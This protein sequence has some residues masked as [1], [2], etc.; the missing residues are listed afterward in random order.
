[1]LDNI[2]AYRR[3]D[4]GGGKAALRNKAACFAESIGFAMSNSLLKSL[5]AMLIIIVARG[6]RGKMAGIEF[7]GSRRRTAYSR[8]MHGF[9]RDGTFAGALKSFSLKAILKKRGEA[10][11]PTCIIIDDT[12]GALSKRRAKSGASIEGAVRIPAERRSSAVRSQ[13]S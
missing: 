4:A 5:A 13:R 7:Y 1:M 10:G 12:T 2:G 3:G 6:F 8:N 9:S 11:E